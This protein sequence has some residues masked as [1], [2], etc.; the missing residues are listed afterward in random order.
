MKTLFMWFLFKRTIKVSG[1]KQVNKN[2]RLEACWTEDGQDGSP[3]ENG[4]TNV[5]SEELPPPPPGSENSKPLKGD[6]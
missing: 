3:T 6:V 4:P 1:E 2:W 5:V